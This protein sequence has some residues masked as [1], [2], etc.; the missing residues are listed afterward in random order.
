MHVGWGREGQPHKAALRAEI[1]CL[2]SQSAC[3]CADDVVLSM[4]DRP[5]QALFFKIVTM[6]CKTIPV[7]DLKMSH[8]PFVGNEASRQYRQTNTR[9]RRPWP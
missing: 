6:G 4:P 9:F 1:L 7:P 3:F 2:V 5:I 8:T